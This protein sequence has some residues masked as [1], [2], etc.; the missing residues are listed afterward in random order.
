MHS[1]I[2]EH[3][4]RGLI[5]SLYKTRK[6]ESQLHTLKF[7]VMM[8]LE[9]SRV[10]REDRPM[11]MLSGRMVSLSR[12]IID[13]LVSGAKAKDRLIE[14]YVYLSQMDEYMADRKINR[15]IDIKERELLSIQ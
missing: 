15:Y 7:A 13:M 12:Y 4:R 5:D 1:D 8:L 2:A 14:I 10:R 9:R 3:R 11:K 6:E